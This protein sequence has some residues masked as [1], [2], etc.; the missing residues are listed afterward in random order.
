[1]NGRPLSALLI[2]AV[3]AF[4][5]AG[6]ITVAA[7]TSEIKGAAILAHPC[8]KV[9]VKQMG[10]VHAGKADEADKLTTKEMQEEWKAM[11]T[12]KRAM[13]ADMAKAYSQT[14]E[15]YAADIKSAGILVVDGEAVLLTV[16][17][18]TRDANGT[19]SS[20]T[21]QEFRFSG[22]QCLVSR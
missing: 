18:Q 12:K 15:Q 2:N 17:K 16:E 14:A 19:S 4:L 11:P 8:G 1:V 3:P 5:L 6:S 20:T 13:V 7:A 9:A 21:R 22:G 10:L